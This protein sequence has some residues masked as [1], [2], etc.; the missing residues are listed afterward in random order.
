MEKANY[1]WGLVERLLQYFRENYGP[2][3]LFNMDNVPLHYVLAR[4]DRDSAAC[5]YGFDHAVPF[6]REDLSLVAYCRS[7]A[8]MR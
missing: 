3:Q 8:E 2:E 4:Y 6:F 7:D 5:A 1:N